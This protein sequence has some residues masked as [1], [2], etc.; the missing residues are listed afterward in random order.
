LSSVQIRQQLHN[1]NNCYKNKQP[2]KTLNNKY[3]YMEKKKKET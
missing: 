1:N 2:V 3:N